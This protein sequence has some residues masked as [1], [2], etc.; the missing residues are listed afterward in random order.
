MELPP[1]PDHLH[2]LEFIRILTP[3]VFS[4][5]FVAGRSVLDVGCGPGQGAWLLANR[6][7][8]QVIAL[9]LD[10]RK[11]RHF[12]KLCSNRNNILKLA[13]DGQRLGFKDQ[14][15]EIVTC[16]EVI[17]HVPRPDMLLSELRRI[18]KEDGLLLLTTPNRSVRLRPLQRPWN[19]EHLR[20]YTLK[21]F[22]RK[23]EKRFPFFE[24]LGIYGDSEP[25]EYYRKMW[26]PS[27]SNAYF[28]WAWSRMKI[29][30][31]E[32]IRK[33][34][35]IRFGRSNL[36]GPPDS[37]SELL[38]RAVP[39]PEPEFWP[40]YADD[41]REHCLNFFIVCGFDNQIIQRAVRQIKQSSCRTFHS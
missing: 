40:F 16:F 6:G 35:R 25:Y 1:K 34:I 3:Y 19:P 28:G 26:Q 23:F 8:E 10:E 36:S 37:K 9:D 12:P 41:V 29:Y 31:P 38:N 11:V 27:L 15:Y 18:L 24:V 20:E 5:P 21:A 39:A 33:G 7:A 30:I 4:H 13:M 14:T 22:Q 17:E 32:S 2:N